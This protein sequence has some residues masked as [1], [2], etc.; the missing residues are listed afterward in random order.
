MYLTYI[1]RKHLLIAYLS[2]QPSLSTVC[3]GGHLDVVFLVPASTDRIS[4]ARPL[5]ELL[6]STARSLRAIGPRDSQVLLLIN[7]ISL[8]TGH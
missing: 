6:I 4:L 5:R 1:Q 7:T 3:V 2:V 8:K